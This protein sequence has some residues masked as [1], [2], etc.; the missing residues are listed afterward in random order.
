MG[1]SAIAARSSELVRL[2]LLQIG[3]GREGEAQ[4]AHGV[5]REAHLVCHWGEV[6]VFNGHA[7]NSHCIQTDH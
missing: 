3:D 5:A 4:Y 7:A 6:L 1:V 2:Y